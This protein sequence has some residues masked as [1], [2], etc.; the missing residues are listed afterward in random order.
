[1]EGSR[2]GREGSES[3]RVVESSRSGREG[4]GGRGH[5]GTQY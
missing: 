1:M 3:G 2:S 4:S 5:S